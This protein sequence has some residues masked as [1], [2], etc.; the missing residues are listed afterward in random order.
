MKP[1]TRPDCQAVTDSI[2]SAGRDGGLDTTLAEHLASCPACAELAAISARIG[3]ASRAAI[4]VAPGF[5]SR[6]VAG[7]TT[8]LQH[9]RRQRIAV[10][11]SLGSAAVAAAVLLA[12]WVPGQPPARLALTEVPSMTEGLDGH[13]ALAAALRTEA[14]VPA[15]AD[16]RAQTT[17]DALTE[18]TEAPE[19][20]EVTEFGPADAERM[21][22]LDAFI[23]AALGPHMA[24]PGGSAAG[25]R[26]DAAELEGSLALTPAQQQRIDAIIAETERVAAQARKALE[27]SRAELDHALDGPN[28][29]EVEVA[30]LVD[31]V[32]LHESQ[33]RKAHVRGWLRARRVLT[34]EQRKALGNHRSARRERNAAR[35]HHDEHD[36]HADMDDLDEMDDMDDPDDA[37][38]AD[39]PDDADDA[40]DARRDG[41]RDA[42]RGHREAMEARREAMREQRDAMHAQREAM[43][44]AMEAK[45]EAMEAKREAMREAMEAHREAMRDSQRVQRQTQREVQEAKREAMRERHD[46]EELER[47][48]EEAE[49][50]IE[51]AMKDADV[52]GTIERAM[53]DAEREME[54]ARKEIERAMEEY[55]QNGKRHGGHGSA[56]DVRRELEQ[57]QRELE[58]A[59]KEMERSLKNIDVNI[60]VEMQR[61]LEEVRRELERAREEAEQDDREQSSAGRPAPPAPPGRP[62]PPAAAGRPAPPAPPGRPTPLIPAKPFTAVGTIKVEF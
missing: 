16:E 5:H 20:P 56:P 39:E 37:D 41:R 40:D 36:M 14:E 18:A 27:L 47:A 59:Q 30:K 23:N 44:G 31:R 58:R 19:A 48:L 55:E 32:S 28:P 1:E 7:A 38:D 4:D 42:M 13:E 61:A 8:R 6:M 3:G 12:V 62:A 60:E 26:E 49:R 35:R 45:R 29:N 54:R 22:R 46:P 11:A 24:M 2:L 34:A 53:K 10:R 25:V 52:E 9:R 21:E 15:P 17:D 51:R 57:A 43:R 50:E 33:V